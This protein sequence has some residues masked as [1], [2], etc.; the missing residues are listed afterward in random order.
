MH[1]DWQLVVLNCI[2]A[3]GANTKSKKRMVAGNK[4]KCE[5]LDS[6]VCMA[7]V[8]VGHKGVCHTSAECSFRVVCRHFGDKDPRITR[9]II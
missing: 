3:I 5:F 4:H 7:W 1:T 9:A 2:M 8:A 6:Y